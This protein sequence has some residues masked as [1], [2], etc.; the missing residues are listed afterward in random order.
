MTCCS[1]PKAG[2]SILEILRLPAQTGH[3]LAQRSKEGAWENFPYHYTVWCKNVCLS[4]S[5]WIIPADGLS[6]S[7]PFQEATRTLGSRKR[8]LLVMACGARPIFAT[9]ARLISSEHIPTCREKRR[10]A[11]DVGGCRIARSQ[12]RHISLFRVYKKTRVFCFFLGFNCDT[13]SQRGRA[14]CNRF[15]AGHIIFEITIN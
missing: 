3:L 4:F 11:H 8:A 14:N 12:G 2:G 6:R 10:R 9:K 13:S 1:C 7:C 5:K 15:K